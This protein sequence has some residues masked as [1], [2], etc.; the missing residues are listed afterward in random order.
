MQATLLT[1]QLETAQTQLTSNQ[2]LAQEILNN[3]E[4]EYKAD[5][6]TLRDQQKTSR[7]GWLAE[8]DAFKTT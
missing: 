7:H 8:K 3:K 2:A 1:S 5:L 6:N 4:T